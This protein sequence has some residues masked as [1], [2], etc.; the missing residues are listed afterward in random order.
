MLLGIFAMHECKTEV[1]WFK[2]VRGIACYRST[3]LISRHIGSA[4]PRKKV[5][6]VSGGESEQQMTKDTKVNGKG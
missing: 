4:Y 5:S 3:L 2:A 6:I 1:C